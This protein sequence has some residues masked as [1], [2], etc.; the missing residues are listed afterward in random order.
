MNAISTVGF[1]IVMALIMV[2]SNEKHTDSMLTLVQE[3]REV[4]NKNTTVLN[5]VLDKVN[6]NETD[7][8]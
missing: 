8:Q 6:N 4:L 5:K 2:Y 3:L 1:P 7:N